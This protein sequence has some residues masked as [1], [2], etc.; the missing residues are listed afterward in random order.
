MSRHAIAGLAVLVL[1]VALDVFAHELTYRHVFAHA[2]EATRCGESGG[3]GAVD[4][5][6]WPR[7][8]WYLPTVVAGLAALKIGPRVVAAA[9]ASTSA[10][11]VALLALGAPTPLG[12]A[13]VLVGMGLFRPCPVVIAAERLT[14][15]PTGSRSVASLVVVALAFGAAADAARL[16]VSSR[17]ANVFFWMHRGPATWLVVI[18]FLAAGGLVAVSRA[19]RTE[20]R[21]VA[22]QSPYR[23]AALREVASSHDASALS[24]VAFLLAPAM[25]VV[26]MG[27]VVEVPYEA[28]RS[29]VAAAVHP[30][31]RSLAGVVF[32]AV[33]WM[34]SRRHWSWPPLTAWGLALGVY[35]AALL[36]A[37]FSLRGPNVV[38]GLPFFVSAA[39]SSVA[40]PLLLSVSLAYA[41]LAGADRYGTLRSGLWLSALAVLPHPLVTRVWWIGRPGLLLLCAAFCVVV[42]VAVTPR[43]RDL[44]RSLSAAPR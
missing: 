20:G 18:L 4:P 10:C 24:A 28:G 31:A 44:H 37:L 34:A 2:F 39:L 19:T 13:L 9:G 3:R 7:W 42:A 27:F 1:A 16:V 30:A 8:L 21:A 14:S 11:G 35:G 38:D 22:R 32:V 23:S 25:V 12:G 17:T 29:A 41:V 15:E 26:S 5:M 36:P 33:G 40:T 6:Q 43:A